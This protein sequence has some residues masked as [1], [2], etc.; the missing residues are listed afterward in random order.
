MPMSLEFREK[1]PSALRQAITEFRDNPKGRSG[2]NLAIGNVP[3]KMHPALIERMFNLDRKDSPVA[4]GSVMYT[5]SGGLSE[6]QKAFQN[7]IASSLVRMSEQDAEKYTNNLAV[8][9]TDGGS[10]A[11]EVAILGVCGPAGTGKEPLLLIDP[12]YTN[13]NEFAKRLGRK[14]ISVRRELQDNGVF[15]LPNPEEMREFIERYKQKHNTVPGGL[16]I[17][18]YDN[19]TGQYFNHK[20]MLE[21]AQICVDFDMYMISD[22][23]YRELCYLDVPGEDFT[24]IWK[25]T[26]DDVPGIEGKRLSIETASKVWNACGLRVGALVGDDSKFIDKAYAVYTSNLSTNTIGQYMFGALAHESRDNLRKWYAER[27]NHYKSMI[28]PFVKQLKRE[29]PGLIVS[30]PDAS[31]YCVLDCKD[32]DGFDNAMSFI[33]YCAIDG[34]AYTEIDGI[35][36]TILAAPMTGFYTVEKGED[37]PGQMQMRLAFVRKPEEMTHAAYVTKG[38]I[39]KYTLNKR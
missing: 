21:F 32:I 26:N 6:T 37:N 36:Y 38:L 9:V 22:E 24:S 20:Q 25:I 2:I 27:R 12:A 39:N 7:I 4:N 23:A 17:I 30:N 33:K 11:M 10:M 16:V 28:P 34:D 5:D 14:T 31:I 1:L 8:Q 19:P 15:T 18:P 29:V 13:Y 35:K 3:D